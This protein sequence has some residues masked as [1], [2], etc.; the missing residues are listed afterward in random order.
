MYQSFHALAQTRAQPVSFDSHPDERTL[1]RKPRAH[2]REALGEIEGAL[3]DDR[4]LRALLDGA[5]ERK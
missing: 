4:A 1:L 5:G 3:G 2:F